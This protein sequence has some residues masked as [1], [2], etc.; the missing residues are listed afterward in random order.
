MATSPF[1]IPCAVLITNVK[2]IWY[3][4]RATNWL[5]INS[6]QKLEEISFGMVFKVQWHGH[7]TWIALRLSWIG[8]WEGW[9]DRTGNSGS[10]VSVCSMWNHLFAMPVLGYRGN[11]WVSEVGI[12]QSY[13]PGLLLFTSVARKEFSQGMPLACIGFF[14][15]FPTLW[16]I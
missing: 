2:K 3:G 10:K 12:W 4:Q 6:D 14:V 11:S 5:W 13:T 1:R 8:L 15:F 7:K 16:R 9:H